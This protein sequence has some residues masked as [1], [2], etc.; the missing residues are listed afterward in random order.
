[1]HNVSEKKNQNVKIFDPIA[2]DTIH[3]LHNIEKQNWN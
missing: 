1:M 3:T 2:E